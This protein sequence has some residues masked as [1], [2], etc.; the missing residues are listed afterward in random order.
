MDAHA[1]L[2]NKIPLILAFMELRVAIKLENKYPKG[3]VGI[4][5]GL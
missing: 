2:K 1:K 5:L 3:W 4:Q